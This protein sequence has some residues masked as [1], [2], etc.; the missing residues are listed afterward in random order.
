[1]KTNTNNINFCLLE[2]RFADIFGA[3]VF[4]AVPTQKGGWKKGGLIKTFFDIWEFEE[5]KKDNNLKMVVGGNA[6]G[7]VPS[8]YE[9]EVY[10]G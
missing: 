8:I 1:M 4:Y 7:F 9:K 2:G 3:D 5:W 10:N 6:E